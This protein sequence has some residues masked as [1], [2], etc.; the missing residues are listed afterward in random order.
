MH[1][2][3]IAPN[4]K[5]GDP[6]SAFPTVGGAP[7]PIIVYHRRISV[8]YTRDEQVNILVYLNKTISSYTI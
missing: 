6:R 3:N 4:R 8:I 5:K 1:C 7:V 2:E